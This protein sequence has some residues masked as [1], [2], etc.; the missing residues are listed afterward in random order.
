M[1]EHDSVEYARAC[2]YGLAGAAMRQAELA[3][4]AL[5]S[6]PARSVLF[7]VTP[8]VMEHEGL[9]GDGGRCA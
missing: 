1:A 3:F 4:A 8:Y 5:P 9:L 7:S 2:L 6:S